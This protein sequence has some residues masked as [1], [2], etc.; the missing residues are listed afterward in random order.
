[1]VRASGSGLLN[2]SMHDRMML[3]IYSDDYE[4]YFRETQEKLIIKEDVKFQNQKTLKATNYL[5][6]KVRFNRA[7]MYD[8]LHSL[9][10]NSK[11]CSYVQECFGVF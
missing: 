3:Q 1:M 9:D 7:D 10:D 11:Y 8:V 5:K 2:T 4:K 6:S